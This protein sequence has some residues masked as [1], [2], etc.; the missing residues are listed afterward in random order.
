[1]GG[2]MSNFSSSKNFG[3][4]TGG[5]NLTEG[6][7]A[8]L[9]ELYVTQSPDRLVTRL[10]FVTTEDS[11]YLGG[12]LSISSGND[13]VFFK[14]YETNIDMYPL[15]GG[16]KDQS[17]LEN[18]GPEGIIQPFGRVLSDTLVS[19]SL[20]GGAE[21]DPIT[22]RPRIGNFI[23]PS[24]MSVYGIEFR[25]EDQIGAG[26]ELTLSL[27]VGEDNTGLVVYRDRKMIVELSTG[28][29]V[30]DWWFRHPLEARQGTTYFL[31]ISF[32]SDSGRVLSVSEDTE[33]LAYVRAHLRPFEDKEVAFTDNHSHTGL[34]A[35]EDVVIGGDFTVNGTA[36]T[37]NT[38]TL[39]ILDKNI[40]LGVADTPTDLTADGG[41]ITLKGS[42]DKTILWDGGSETWDFNQ[43]VHVEGDLSTTGTF[44]GNGSGITDIDHDMHLPLGGTTSGS[45]GDTGNF[46]WTSLGTFPPLDTSNSP[47]LGFI[48]RGS[49]L[50]LI[51]DLGSDQ[52]LSG[53][54]YQNY[55]LTSGAESERGLR[56]VTVYSSTAAPSTGWNEVL[57]E[58]ET[59]AP[60][61]SPLKL[62]P[63]ASGTV[64]RY[65][66]IDS[67]NQVLSSWGATWKGMRAMLAQVAD[68][69]LYESQLT[70]LVA[71]SLSNVGDL[72]VNSLTTVQSVV[73]G[74]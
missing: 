55:V 15:W 31:E 41:G 67:S 3:T 48:S 11:I 44:V 33:G 46:G 16:I 73:V 42:T 45:N 40:E 57:G 66:I 13:A 54:L 36:T 50:R 63:F 18:Q 21:T 74:T 70:T 61:L 52:K 39:E 49:P 43:N 20:T 72:S 14:N 53:M 24:D 35:F 10:P 38:V 34:T 71:D 28:S 58:R 47:P 51:L 4:T 27:H 29:S 65:I 30:I 6:E 2:N 8:V 68:S 7:Q 19:T 17:L 56:G 9:A 32:S 64:G 26:T 12:I 37:I 25:H 62:V 59:E 22:Y 5:T 60:H 69:P 23:L 1:M